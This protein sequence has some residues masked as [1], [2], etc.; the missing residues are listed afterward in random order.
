MATVGL[1]KGTENITANVPEDVAA[2]IDQLAQASDLSRNK[3]VGLLL[4]DAA[5]KRRVFKVEV[6]TV[7]TESSP[8]Y[9]TKN[10]K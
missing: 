7:V 8:P 1:R 6:R 2:E 9:R 5:E 10:T 4:R 3:Y